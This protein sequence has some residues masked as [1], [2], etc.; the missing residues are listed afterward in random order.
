MAYPITL[1]F[2]G[3]AANL[4]A[5][6]PSTSNNFLDDQW[7]KAPADFNGSNWQ[8]GT[9]TGYSL[10]VFNGG[11]PAAFTGS[12][13]PTS[14][15]SG[16]DA[17]VSL[18]AYNGTV[19]AGTWTFG[20]SLEAQAVSGATM[21]ACFRLYRG[22]NPTGSGATEITTGIAETG[23]VVLASSPQAVSVNVALPAIKLNNEHL[24][25]QVAVRSLGPGVAS[26]DCAQFQDVAATG[27]AAIK[28]PN[29]YE[30]FFPNVTAYADAI[31]LN[32]TSA[33]SFALKESIPLPASETFQSAASA[34]SQPQDVSPIDLAQGYSSPA[35]PWNGV[36]WEG[37]GSLVLAPITGP[38]GTLNVTLGALT[39]SAAGVVTVS[40]TTSKT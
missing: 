30:G 23:S 32:S 28:S 12:P 37:F 19:E 10:Q 3:S 9:T 24:F 15:L 29:F 7:P 1:Y 25:L 5:T 21:T 26:A 36:V 4:W 6:Y 34:T 27:V 33:G 18:L 16:S 11:T 40:G 20:V 2:R 14:G 13:L 39:D 35:S 31:I 38:I 17:G 8:P 22:T